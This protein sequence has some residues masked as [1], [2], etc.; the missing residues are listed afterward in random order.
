MSPLNLGMDGSGAEVIRFSRVEGVLCP[1]C[2]GAGDDQRGNG[3]RCG[4]C[5]LGNGT[6]VCTRVEHGEQNE[7]THGWHH[8]LERCD[9]GHDHVAVPELPRE[10]VHDPVEE[11][12]VADPR[13]QIRTYRSHDEVIDVWTQHGARIDNRRAELVS[14]Y[15]YFESGHYVEP[16]LIVGRFENVLGKTFR[17]ASRQAD[18]RWTHKAKRLPALMYKRQEFEDRRAAGDRIF[19][20]EGEKDCDALLEFTGLLGICAPGGAGNFARLSDLLAEFGGLSVGVVADLDEAGVRHALRTVGRLTG[21]AEDV[22]LFAPVGG[23]DVAEALAAQGGQPPS[24]DPS[25]AERILEEVAP[26]NLANRFGFDVGL[27]RATVSRNDPEQVAQH[28]L[29]RALRYRAEREHLPLVR[30]EDIVVVE[31][32]RARLVE[33][34]ERRNL[35]LEVCNFI[36]VTREGVVADRVAENFL[37]A[38]FAAARP[39]LPE[40]TGLS[41]VPLLLPDGRVISEPGWDRETG[42]WYQ[43]GDLDALSLLDPTPENIAKSKALIERAFGDFQ[44]EDRSTGWPNL[45]AALLIAVCRSAVVGPTPGFVFSAP[46][47]GSGKTLA[48]QAISTIATGGSPQTSLPVREEERKKELASLAREGAPIVFFDNAPQ[49]VLD[50]PSLAEFIT[51]RQQRSR[52]LGVSETQTS[53]N[54]A[55]VFITGNNVMLS[56]E[57]ERR[58]LRVAFDTGMPRPW[59]REVNKF[60][61]PDLI[62]EVSSRRGEFLQAVLTLVRAG[63]V[64]V[65]RREAGG[66]NV[67]HG[68]IAIRGDFIDFWR[69]IGTTVEICGWGVVGVSREAD[70][71]VGLEDEFEIAEFLARMY[72]GT[73]GEPAT[74]YKFRSIAADDL[75]RDEIEGPSPANRMAG[76]NWSRA[77]GEFWRSISRRVYVTE[78]GVEYRVVR[79]ELETAPR[80]GTSQ[81][82]R[83][84]RWRIEKRDP[85]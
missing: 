22:K 24:P 85:T 14:V 26:E 9:C 71:A 55:V 19:I 32:A 37:A 27:L 45:M 34:P 58:I 25:I 18:G 50:S 78:A 16:R 84:P 6:I 51:S 77:F 23:D 74:E 40:L 65:H 42:I 64:E 41:F 66:A 61:C 81:E 52:I 31:G 53:E 60:A 47:I 68:Q 83:R 44:F 8:K 56:A 63:L 35:A 59:D 73:S 1:V 69:V 54:R 29:C 57:L 2:G 75:F 30:G 28:A 4:G 62:E 5:R 82:R 72:S 21:I 10:E 13:S 11:E 70:A 17:Q 48:A 33:A 76:G 20:C 39:E 7:R 43:P 49:R 46:Q 12:I 15:P 79:S 67:A 80:K 3:V 38:A 36:R